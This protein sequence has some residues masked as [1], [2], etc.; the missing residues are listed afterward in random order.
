MTAAITL[1]AKTDQ[2]KEFDFDLLI[3]GEK[4]IKAYLK[5]TGGHHE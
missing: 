5:T 1:L 3:V 4:L 2:D